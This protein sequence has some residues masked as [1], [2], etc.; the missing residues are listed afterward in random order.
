LTTSY[1]SDRGY[2]SGG[3]DI[4]E[5]VVQIRRVAKV[6]KGGRRLSFNAMVVVGDGKGGVGVGLGKGAAVPDAVRKGTAI[7]KKHMHHISLSGSTIPHAVRLRTIASEVIMKPAAPGVGIVAGGAVRAVMEAV[8]IKDV[9]AKALGSRNPIN[10]VKATIAGLDKLKGGRGPEVA[11]APE[12]VQTRPAQERPSVVAVEH[13]APEA[14]V[15]ESTVEPE[16]AEAV[17]EPTALETVTEPA[18]EPEAPKAVEEPM[19]EPTAKPEAS[20]AIKEPVAEAVS[21]P[22]VE[23]TKEGEAPSPS[24]P[25]RARAKQGEATDSNDEETDD[26]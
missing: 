9:V 20:E 26:E 10:M 16:A 14:V 6:V 19:I 11:V 8:G 5:K 21:I 4:V 13:T 17:E 18:A 22:D 25:R 7:A 2:D 23:P 1:G 15:A 12:S 3:S 24:R